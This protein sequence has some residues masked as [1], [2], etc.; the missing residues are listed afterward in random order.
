M[1][2]VW[3]ETYQKAPEEKV[4]RSAVVTLHVEKS[5]V[6]NEVP[7]LGGIVEVLDEVDVD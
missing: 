4:A 2:K 7:Q 6:P 1:S 5:N 3:Q